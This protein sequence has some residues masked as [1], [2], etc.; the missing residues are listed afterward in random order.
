[1]VKGS[2]DWPSN[3]MHYF[4]AQRQ[5]NPRSYTMSL[6]SSRWWHPRNK[7]AVWVIKMTT[8]ILSSPIEV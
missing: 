5:D 2:K 7:K 4:F 6:Q 3:T 1:M 8:P